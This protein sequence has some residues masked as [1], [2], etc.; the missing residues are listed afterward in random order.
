MMTMPQDSRRMCGIGL[1]VTCPFSAA[2][3]SPPHFATSACEASWQVVEKR[4]TM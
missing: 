2:V 1:S 4:K 3:E